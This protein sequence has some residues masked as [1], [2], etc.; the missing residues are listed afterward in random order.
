[1]YPI[2]KVPQFAFVLPGLD[3]N[4]TVI[5]PASASRKGNATMF[6]NSELLCWMALVNLKQRLALCPLLLLTVEVLFVMTFVQPTGKSLLAYEPKFSENSV[7][8]CD[9]AETNMGAASSIS[10]NMWKALLCLFKKHKIF[11]FNTF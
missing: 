8:V 7:T 1:M 3:Q 11:I 2:S 9:W 10:I 6:Q 5:E 4:E